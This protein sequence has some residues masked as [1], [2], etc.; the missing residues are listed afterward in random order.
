MK[1][2]AA[3]EYL[4]T[5]EDRVK[6]RDGFTELLGDLL[7]TIPAI[8]TANAHRGILIPALHKVQAGV[9][10]LLLSLNET[11]HH[12]LCSFRCR[13]PCIPVSVPACS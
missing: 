4:G 10:T 8:K 6:N 5:S 13:R 1:E 12:H 3:D 11:H 2:L 7:F 9:I